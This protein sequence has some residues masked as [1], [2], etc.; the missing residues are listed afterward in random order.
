MFVAYDDN[1]CSRRGLSVKKKSFESEVWEQVGNVCL[2]E[3]TTSLISLA[4][5]P[6]T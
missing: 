4:V 5:D 2:T 3:N 1:T 6:K